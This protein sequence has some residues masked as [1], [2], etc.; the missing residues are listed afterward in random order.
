[1]TVLL[2]VHNGEAYLAAAIDSVLRQTY[3]DL[4][5]IVIDDGS[6][7]GSAAI[8]ADC[9]DPRLRVVRNPTNLGLIASLNKGLALARGELVARMDADD[10]ADPLRLELQ[11]RRFQR[12]PD[13]VALGTGIAYI[14]PA[15]RIVAVPPRQAQGSGLLRW[16][17]LRGTCIYHPSLMLHRGRAGG[18]AHYSAQFVHAED[19]ELVLRLS[20]RAKI[21]NLAE[22]LLQ[23]RQ[24]PGSVSLRF[25]DQQRASAVRALLQHLQG[26][27]G[28][29]LPTAQAQALLDPRLL[30]GRD[31]LVADTPIAAILELERRFL[32]VETDVSRSE[33]AAVARDVAFFLW[34]LVA[35]AA[36]DWRGGALLR[37]RLVT[38]AACLRTLARRPRAA[39]A[40]LDARPA[41]RTH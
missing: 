5:L 24:H 8:V 31:A 9:R 6:T 13:L 16:R 28:I 32:A 14:D 12:E 7:D 22:V 15:G 19:Y 33:R 11:V 38:T 10:V 25:R 26:R 30:F 37:R 36:T 39:L 4:E 34:K 18:D 17:L 40:A 3:A 27:Y 23:L 2:P 20:R 41:G 35:I 29:N 1:V 21:D